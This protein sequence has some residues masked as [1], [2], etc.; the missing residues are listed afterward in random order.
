MAVPQEELMKMIKSQRDQATP[1]GMV[2]TTEETVMSDATT[3]PM[4]APMSTPEP[5]MGS[6]ESAMLNLS[7]AMDLLNQS[8]PGIGV[9]SKEGKQVLDAIRVITGILGPDKE[10]TDEL[11]PTEILNMLQTLPQA[12]GATPESKAMS[13]APAIPGMMPTPPGGG[14][15]PIPQPI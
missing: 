3:P 12:G 7:M 11:Q 5:K 6:K 1:G 10:R 2:E 15:L 14:A 9:S 13:S 8:L 4:A